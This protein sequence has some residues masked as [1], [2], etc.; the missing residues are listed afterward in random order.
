MQPTDPAGRDLNSSRWSCGPGAAHPVAFRGYPGAAV[1]HCDAGPQYISPMSPAAG[2]TRPLLLILQKSVNASIRATDLGA[3]ELDGEEWPASTGP[4]G[5]IDVPGNRRTCSDRTGREAGR[6]RRRVRCGE[7]SGDGQ[8][9]PA[10]TGL[11]PHAGA[12]E[13]ARGKDDGVGKG[14]GE[15]EYG[16]EGR[17]NEA[18]ESRRSERSNGDDGRKERDRGGLEQGSDDGGGRHSD[19]GV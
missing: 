1:G 15:S 17:A 11:R 13:R 10:D 7:R 14:G 5:G 18:A 2:Q 3:S 19:S 8:D 12:Q 9:R 6:S 16:S 4:C